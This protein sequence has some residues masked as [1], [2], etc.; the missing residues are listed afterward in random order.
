MNP[1]YL[2][3]LCIAVS[4]ILIASGWKDV[5]ISHITSRTLLLF[6][7]AWFMLHPVRWP[8][9]NVIVSGSALLM[10]VVSVLCL[11]KSEGWLSRIHYGAASLLLGS[12]SSLLSLYLK[13]APQIHSLAPEWTA[14]ALIGLLAA[15]L[16]RQQSMLIGGI[17][18]GL[19]L[20]ELLLNR[21]GN[22]EASMLL[23]DPRIQDRWWLTLFAGLGA[24]WLLQAVREGSRKAV[25]LLSFKWRRDDG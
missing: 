18:L 11:I 2:S 10:A 8:I 14:S 6:F 19:L 17:S 20:S 1:G 9:G 13:A 25:R 23:G 12:V 24:A 3:V 4:L 7:A 15:L 21:S 22:Q 5:F 16:L